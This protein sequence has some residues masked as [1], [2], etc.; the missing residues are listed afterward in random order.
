MQ[1]TRAA[2]AGAEQKAAALCPPLVERMLQLQRI[3]ADLCHYHIS[4]PSLSLPHL[5]P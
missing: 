1:D 2:E 4:S 3:K 5:L